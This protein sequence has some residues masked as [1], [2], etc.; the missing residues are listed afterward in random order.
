MPLACPLELNIS[1]FL[2]LGLNRNTNSSQVSS[3]PAF[4]L[5]LAQV[6]SGLWTLTRSTPLALLFSSL[7]TADLGTLELFEFESNSCSLSLSVYIHTYT[8]ICM[9]T[10]THTHTHTF[11]WFSFFSFWPPAMWDLSCLTRDQ[12]H[13]PCIGSS[14]S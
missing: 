12:T 10:H 14:G 5:E 9:Y 3:L 13:D 6:S 1:I 4:R 2:P 7:P 8:H 11:C